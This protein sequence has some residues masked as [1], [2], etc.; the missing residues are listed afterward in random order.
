MGF[1]RSIF[2]VLLGLVW[3][4]VSPSQAQTF[5]FNDGTTQGWSLSQMFVTSDGTQFTPVIG[6]VLG[7]SGTSLSVSTGS[8]LIGKSD[9]NDIYL[10]SPDLSS[11]ASWQG[12][13]GYSIDMTRLLHSDCWGDFANIFYL[14]LQLRVIDT[15]DGNKEKLY[16]EYSGSSFVFHDIKTYSHL[17]QFTWTPSWLADPR[18]KVKNIRIRITGPGD[19][20]AEC[21]YHGSWELDNV[22]AV[23]GSGTTESITLTAPN[24]GQQWEA[25]TSHLISWTGQ[26]IDGKSV[27]IEYS[28]NGG[29][30]YTYITSLVNSG[31]AGSYNWTVPNAPS[32]S[33]RIRVSTPAASD[34]SDAN[35][36]IT[37]TPSITVNVPNGGED[38]SVGSSQYIVWDTHLFTNPVA[39]EYS[40][41]GGTSYSTITSSGVSGGSYTWTVPNTASPNCLVRVSNAAGGAPS[42]VSNAVF[43][44][45]STVQANTPVGA[46]VT[47]E[48]SRAIRLSFDSVAVAGNTQAIVVPHG[49][50]P[51][52]NMVLIPA[53]SPVFYDV[54]ST[55]AFVGTVTLEFQYND[56]H[57]GARESGLRLIRYDTLQ[58]RWEDITTALDIDANTIAGVSSHL[59]Q[60]ALAYSTG[61]PSGGE[62]FVTTCAD[63]GMGSLREALNQANTHPGPDTILFGIAPGVP[64]HDAA[65]GVW[66]ITP[67]TNLPSITDDGLILS[68][69]SQ[70]MFLG[71]DANP[72]GPEIA[73]DGRDILYGS[74]GLTVNARNV[75]ING[76]AIGNCSG[77]GLLI[78]NSELVQVQG[79][80]IGATAR[81]D[82]AAPN[83]Y[84]IWVEGHS[85]GIFIGPAD[86][87]PSIVSGNLNAG[88][89][90]TDTSSQVIV[91][92]NIIGLT[93]DALK[94]IGNG[95]Y[96]GIV[97]TN[98]ADS[99]QVVANTIGGNRYGVF[100]M[101]VRWNLI[102]A[103]WI[104]R[105]PRDPMNNTVGNLFD[106]VHITGTSS[107]NL[108]LENVIG[109]N[110]GSGVRMYGTDCAGN[111][112]MHNSISR[113]Q[114]A[115]IL[116]DNGG[117]IVVPRPTITAVAGGVVQGTTLPK[118]HVEIYTDWEGEGEFF[119]G[120]TVSDSTGAFLWPGPFT[121]P[122][123]NATALVIDSI[124]NTSP[125]SL[126]YAIPTVSVQVLGGTPSTFAL[127]QNYPN[128]FNPKTVVRGQWPVTSV[129]RLTVY[130]ILGRRV[131]V[132]ADGRYPAG[133]YAFTFDGTNL[134]SGLYI[135]RL[136]TGAFSAVRKMLLV[137]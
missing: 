107:T 132:L 73:I 119:E 55:A 39:I 85:R 68:G 109:F 116:Y 56:T 128:P 33:C 2:L 44:I 54:T 28:T 111:P 113:N 133:K 83:S 62:I 12:I 31:T 40:T 120:E 64:G 71:T 110:K 99:V 8:L 91:V 106:G 7:N 98:G 97:L 135:Y 25:E 104:G 18:Y 47:V 88:V 34:V 117:I 48:P 129:V 101:D 63:T 9:Q 105:S 126:P 32:A 21:W 96:G 78:Q 77:T 94:P 95:N 74:T 43:T 24:G 30:S 52:S 27:Q 103:N 57:L 61:T 67:Q 60:F 59:S 127:E 22:T 125:F 16:A 90:I 36:E 93:R 4:Q 70:S 42:D 23:G 1:I 14:Q 136:T 6:Y 13:A 121:S 115:G 124:G 35:F 41:N 131:A 114:Y 118:A 45:S 72:L 58:A 49:P 134:A 19:V 122:A 102:R 84:G 3:C 81:G 20:M 50:L 75:T 11:S 26:Q 86:T 17:Y 79:C 37:A 15:G 10:E 46:G 69:F 108:I 38:W 82:T 130:D 76:L 137:R 29:S 80:N 112:I 100:L 89:T 92:G 5:D 87:I 66:T 51:P 123:S 53:G 65:T